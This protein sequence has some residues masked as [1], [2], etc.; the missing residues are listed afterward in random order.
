MYKRLRNK[1][2]GEVK[3]T[4]ASYYA[5]A[6]IQTNGD[7]RKTWQMISELT[8]RQK[9][10]ASVKELKL[11]DNSVT[12]SHELSNAF[13][14][15][16]SAI[17]TKLANEVPLVTDGSNYADY[18]VSSSNKFF[19]SLVSC[20]DVFSLLNKLSKSKT[21]GLD[22]ISAKLIRECAYLISIR[23]CDIFNKS[24]SSDRVPDEMSELT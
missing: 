6:F 22:H 21:S 24:P 23:L 19:F 13:N 11:N 7:S 20:S 15:H 4:K 8:S 1:I 14:D 5:N 16:Y 12:N 9:N 2:S 18:V 3:S 10:S 17:G